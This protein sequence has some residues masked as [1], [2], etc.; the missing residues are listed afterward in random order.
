MIRGLIITEILL[1][2]VLLGKAQNEKDYIGDTRIDTLLQLHQMQNQKFPFIDGYRIQIY[3][4]TGNA[5][6]DSA[7][8]VKKRFEQNNP[9]VQAYI[10]FREPY[11]RV[12]VGNFRTRLEAIRFLYHIHKQYPYSWEIKD[13]IRFQKQKKDEPLNTP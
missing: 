10:S 6:L 7:W 2:F 4:E 11:Y 8:S 13:K 3:K 9:P 1:L 5:A 12:R